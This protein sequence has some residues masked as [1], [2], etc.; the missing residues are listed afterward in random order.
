MRTIYNYNTI[1]LYITSTLFDTSY[2]RLSKQF[3]THTD[4]ICWFTRTSIRCVRAHFRAYCICIRWNTFPHLVLI[5]CRTI[6]MQVC[7]VAY[8]YVHASGYINNKRPGDHHRRPNE[9]RK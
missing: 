2:A 9:C 6:C 4:T 7:M 3:H 5:G 8:T 1:R